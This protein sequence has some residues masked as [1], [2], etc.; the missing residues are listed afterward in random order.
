MESKHS[1]AELGR[2]ALLTSAQRQAPHASRSAVAARGRR[3]DCFAKTKAL[4]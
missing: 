3:I 4:R 1:P 2:Q